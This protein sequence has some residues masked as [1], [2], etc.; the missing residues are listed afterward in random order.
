MI[1]QDQLRIQRFLRLCL[2]TDVLKYLT[3]FTVSLVSVT[4]VQ[5]V[6]WSFHLCPTFMLSHLFS[7]LMPHECKMM[8][9]VVYGDAFVSLHAVRRAV[10]VN[11]AF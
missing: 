1:R 2:R 9:R 10:N 3:F 4:F 8:I 7:A 11:Q 6:R 5:N